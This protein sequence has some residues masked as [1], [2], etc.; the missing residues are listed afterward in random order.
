MPSKKPIIHFNTEQ[1]I[2]DKMKVIADENNRSLAKEMEYLCK[3]RIKEYEDV[4][5]EIDFDKIKAK[6][7]KSATDTMCESM[8]DMILKMAKKTNKTPRELWENQ[9]NSMSDKKKAN[10]NFSII[11][12]YIEQRITDSENE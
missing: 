2:I 11:Q 6:Q 5:G 10:N 3:Q 12:E 1:W 7:F 8:Y 4:H 9:L